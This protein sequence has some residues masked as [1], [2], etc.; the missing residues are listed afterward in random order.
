MSAYLKCPQIEQCK[1]IYVEYQSKVDWRSS[2]DILHCNPRFHN[3]PR[4]DCI[5]YETDD[6]LIAMG[7]L[8]FVFRCH[9]P[10]N[11]VIDFAM[12]RTF[13]KT[14][15]Q[16]NTRTDCPIREKMPATAAS[17]VT[18][19]HVVH[20][21]LLCPI[22]GGKAEMHYIIDCVDEDMYLRVNNID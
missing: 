17:F 18:L 21:T 7:E 6:D 14:T 12:V 15:W 10:G 22:F 16:P 2:R 19:E 8:F 20:G 4:F 1:V 13:R 3:A 11:V 9:L 5:I